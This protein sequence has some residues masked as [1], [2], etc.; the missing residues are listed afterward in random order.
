MQRQV[1][2]FHYSNSKKQPEGC[3]DV[4]I[5]SQAENECF[6]IWISIWV[7][8]ILLSKDDEW[9]LCK[10]PEFTP[11]T[12]K[13]RIT[14]KS[15]HHIVKIVPLTTSIPRCRKSLAWFAEPS[16]F[17]IKKRFLYSICSV[18]FVIYFVLS[19]SKLPSPCSY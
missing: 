10:H 4:T 8:D 6:F 17:D 3:K 11:P 18:L 7:G 2:N 12:K 14:E 1:L 13:E 5:S 19:R 16:E 9:A 15:S